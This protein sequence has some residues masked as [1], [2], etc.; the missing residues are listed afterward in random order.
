MIFL[1]PNTNLN[2]AKNILNKAQLQVHLNQQRQ[3]E[4]NNI[5]L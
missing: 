1:A 5:D 2:G 3:K 4:S